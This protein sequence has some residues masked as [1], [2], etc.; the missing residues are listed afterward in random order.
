[1]LS[2]IVPVFN[3]AETL[4]QCL[5]S[6]LIQSY[7]DIEIIIV[8]DGSTDNSI[9]IV[10][11]YIEKYKDQIKYFELTENK[12]IGNA[13]NIGLE[14]A[15]GEFITFV[16][17][18]DWIDSNLYQS[19]INAMTQYEAEIAVFG[20]KNEYD[21]YINSKYRYMYKNI[22]IID[23][24]AALRLLCRTYANDIY[25]SPIV[26]QKIYK[27]DFLKET[28]LSFDCK[29]YYYDDEFTFLL[30]LNKCNVVL[31][32]EGFYHYYQKPTSIM[33]T[34]SKRHISDKIYTFKNIFSFLVQK[35]LYSHHKKDFWA[36]FVK[37]FRT[38]FDTLFSVEPS[39][40]TQKKYLMYFWES[41]SQEF[42]YKDYIEYL[43]INR[44]KSLW[45][46]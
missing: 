15:A 29:S 4:S 38:L 14:N 35:N 33:H 26:N 2:V 46:L 3:S 30:F 43:D 39:I 44:I 17:A 9:D 37:S 41:F 16:D 45:K 24:D 8:N 13:R 34:F 27:T 11:Y 5:S 10:N 36:F 12:G 21:N 40:D 6:I 19:A 23:N 18:D 25:I 28:K 42:N 20:M 7:K 31:S 32:N 1:M 22:N